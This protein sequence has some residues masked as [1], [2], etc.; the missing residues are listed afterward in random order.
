[1]AGGST[2]TVPA[3]LTPGEFVIKRESAEML[4]LPF[5]RRLNAVSDNAAH[6][7]IDALIAQSEL[8]GMK[9]MLGGGEV[10]PGYENGGSVPKSILNIPFSLLA[11]ALN[12]PV[13]RTSTVL[14]PEEQILMELE[15]GAHF[16][17]T[18][19]PSPE[20]EI[21]SELINVAKQKEQD[22]PIASPFKGYQDGDE[23]AP[24]LTFGQRFV[25]RFPSRHKDSERAS[26][27]ER[28]L[29]SLIDFL[30]PQ[31]KLDIALSA[32]PVG[33]LG[34]AGKKALGK[35]GRKAIEEFM[36]KAMPETFT[37]GKEFRAT[38]PEIDWEKTYKGSE[39]RADAMREYRRR[40]LIE[41]ELDL[42]E[43]IS[44]A[45]YSPLSELSG[46]ELLKSP[47]ILYKGV[48]SGVEDVGD[49]VEVIKKQGYQEGGGVGEAGR[50][51]APGA[52]VSP[53]WGDV[54]PV[55]EAWRQPATESVPSP[56]EVA[57]FDKMIKMLM[58]QGA[59]EKARQAGEQVNPQAIERR[60]ESYSLDSLVESKYKGKAGMQFPKFDFPPNWQG[61]NPP[62]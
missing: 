2:D 60:S 35:K 49:L 8:A 45:D 11:N 33:A 39:A 52:M 40:K 29:T 25:Q 24:E 58:V 37:K 31:S 47:D 6:N 15:S 38:M 21:L 9:P 59:L 20:E 54:P 41:S 42:Y 55:P 36:R 57:E 27:E 1:M 56:E 48:S 30:I 5:L 12:K 34:K 43:D 26:E 50:D 19:V 61:Y 18:D 7:S 22:R 14:S 32:V 51:Y 46:S 28:G 13:P 17:K 53:F 23:V 4:G 3:R 10:A 44:G 16:P 62:R